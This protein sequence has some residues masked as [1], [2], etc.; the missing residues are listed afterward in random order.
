MPMHTQTRGRT[1]MDCHEIEELSGAYALDALS[2]EERKAVDEHLADC[3]KCAQ[4]IRQLQAVVDLF[5]LSVP[6]VDPPPHMKERIFAKIQTNT[7]P[8]IPVTPVGK[9][10]TH[11]VRTPRVR[12]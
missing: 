6:A 3:P 2:P 10:P 11:P 12:A 8:N 5:P 1:S 9:D 4:E 7:T